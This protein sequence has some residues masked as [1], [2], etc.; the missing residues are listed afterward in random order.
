MINNA[1]LRHYYFTIISLKFNSYVTRS[2]LEDEVNDESEETSEQTKLKLYTVR[3]Q[4]KVT[5]TSEDDRAKYTCE[6]H[7]EALSE[8]LKNTIQLRVLCEYYL[9]LLFILYD[10]FR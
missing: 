2:S 8:P 1:A 3:S 4:I 5:A 6:A 10:N 9:L 7:H